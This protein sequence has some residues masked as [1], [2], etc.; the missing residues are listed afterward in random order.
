[1]GGLQNLNHL[2]LPLVL[3]TKYHVIE[4][5][6]LKLIFGTLRIASATLTSLYQPHIHT[7]RSTLTDPLTDT[8]RYRKM[9]AFRVASSLRAAPRAIALPRVMVARRGYADIA[10]DRLKLS[11]VLPHSVSVAVNS[12]QRSS[13]SEGAV[14]SCGVVSDGWKAKEGRVLIRSPYTRP[15]VSLR[16]TSPL[17]PVTWV[18]SPTTFLPLKL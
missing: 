4:G 5:A 11:L 18:S 8:L 6:T 12:G 9:S 1:M 13:E 2:H 16:S 10:D 15:R 7:C 14:Q 17:L 3:S